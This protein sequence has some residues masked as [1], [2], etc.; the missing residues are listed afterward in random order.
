MTDCAFQTGVVAMGSE[1]IKIKDKAITFCQR[2]PIS[3]MEAD[4]LHIFKREPC[5]NQIRNQRK[6]LPSTRNIH[7]P[8]GN[9]YAR[10]HQQGC[11]CTDKQ[12]CRG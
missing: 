12:R 9:S 1:D 10:K 6:E 2:Y 5:Q 4:I 8:H 7:E 3:F 11:D